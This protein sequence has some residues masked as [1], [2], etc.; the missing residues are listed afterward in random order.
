MH[1]HQLQ[2][3]YHQQR[4]SPVTLPHLGGLWTRLG[5]AQ[6]PGERR[7]PVQIQTGETSRLTPF[8]SEMTRPRPPDTPSLRC[9]GYSVGPILAAGAYWQIPV[10]FFFFFFFRVV[11]VG[12][13]GGGGPTSHGP[14]A[15][16]PAPTTGSP[17]PHLP[18]RGHTK[19]QRK[20][21]SCHEGPPA[22]N[23]NEYHMMPNHTA[24]KGR[25][26]ATPQCYYD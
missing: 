9:L 12:G 18:E 22:A 19:A 11:V 20:T 6:A 13:V 25:G 24:E 8:P 23:Q 15:V 7:V 5:A 17:R 14:A 4:A 1:T 21:E 26:G 3:T 2:R 16:Q 10:R